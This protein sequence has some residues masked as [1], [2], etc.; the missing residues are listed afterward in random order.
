MNIKLRSVGLFELGFW[1]SKVRPYR[2]GKRVVALKF[3]G[4]SLEEGILLYNMF[5]T[6]LPVR[7]ILRCSNR[8]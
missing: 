8:F 1:Q 2:T 7:L 5:F 6:V 3:Q 4:Y